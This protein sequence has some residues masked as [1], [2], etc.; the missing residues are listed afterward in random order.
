MPEMRLGLMFFSL[1]KFMRFLEFLVAGRVPLTFCPALEK[2][3]V[4][5]VNGYMSSA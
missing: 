1:F 4:V 3:L 2:L 5:K